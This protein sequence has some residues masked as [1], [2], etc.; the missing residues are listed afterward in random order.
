MA[1]NVKGALFA[2]Q[3]AARQMEKFKMPGTIIF[4]AAT[5]TG[6][7]TDQARPPIDFPVQVISSLFALRESVTP[8]TISVKAVFYR[9]LALWPARLVRRIFG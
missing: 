2:A 1:V 6:T 5:T 4:T 9:R 3:G 7:L 8:S